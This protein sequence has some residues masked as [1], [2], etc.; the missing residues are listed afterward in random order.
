MRV[1]GRNH[2]KEVLVVLNK[3]CTKQNE[4]FWMEGD[5]NVR[6]DVCICL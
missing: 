2:R 6:D 4:P 5:G 3:L 1:Q